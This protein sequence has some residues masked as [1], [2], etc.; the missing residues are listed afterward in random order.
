MKPWRSCVRAAVVDPMDRIL[1][2]Q[3]DTGV[4]ATPGGGIEAGETDE[5]ALR[6]E[7]AEEIGLT[8]FVLGPCLWTR[9]HAFDMA[10]HCGQ[11]ERCYLV[12][13]A[14]FAPEPLV[15]PAIEGIA[16]IRWWTRGEL[17]VSTAVFAPERLAAWFAALLDDG[18]P[19]EPI[20]V[21]V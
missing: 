10:A 9:E 5:Q 13:A 14:A 7:L 15:D 1:L 11:R 12:L 2:V 19:A 3:F 20:D 18:P 6:R 8:R 21:G 4:W 16:Q 17:A